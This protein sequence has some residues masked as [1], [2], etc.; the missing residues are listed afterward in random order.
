MQSPLGPQWLEMIVV[1]RHS[2][3]CESCP[4]LFVWG[5]AARTTI[6]VRQ[7]HEQIFQGPSDGMNGYDLA[8]RQPD[9]PG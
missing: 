6:L 9:F 5:L 8:S 3:L 1:T 7:L 2:L 4:I